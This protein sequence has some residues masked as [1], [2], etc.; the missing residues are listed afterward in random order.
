[1]SDQATATFV[2]STERTPFERE[3]ERRI[4]DLTDEMMNQIDSLGRKHKATPEQIRAAVYRF[5]GS[6]L[7]ECWE[8]Y[9]WEEG[10]D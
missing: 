5:G 7:A 10:E 8:E 9:V 1:M 4:I 6:D 2:E 3:V